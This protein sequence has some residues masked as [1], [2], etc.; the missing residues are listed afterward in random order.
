MRGKSTVYLQ[1]EEG[2]GE[3]KQPFRLTSPCREHLMDQQNDQTA[4]AGRDF[5]RP[6]T[7]P[8]ALL[9]TGAAQA[10]CLGLRPVRCCASPRMEISQPLLAAHSSVR[11]SFKNKKPIKQKTA[12]F[13]CMFKAEF[14]FQL[15]PTA[16]CSFIGYY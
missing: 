6:S 2:R 13:Y 7:S 8:A 15:L 5:W 3:I 10:G 1:K 14:V 12:T 11:S 9:G 4:E 16:S